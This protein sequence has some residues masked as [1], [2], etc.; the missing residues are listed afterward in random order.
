MPKRDFLQIPDLTADGI[1]SLLELAGRMKAGS[2]RERPLVG[3]T[4]AMVFAKSSTR[5]RVSFEVGA[6]QLGG[7]ALFL[8]SRD[9]QIGR[10]EPIKDTA[11]V[12]SRYVDGIMIRT[13]A[14]ADVVE[15]ARHATV[16]VINGLTDFLHP[17]QILADVMTMQEAFGGWQGRVVAWVGD[18]NN[19]AN[20]WLHA[21]GVLGFE[22]RVAC[23]E[24]YEPDREVFERAKRTAKVSVYEDPE[25]AVRGA[26]VVTTDVW[27]SMGQ[28]AEVDARMLAFKGYNVDAQLM[29]LASPDAIFLHC[30]PAHRGEEVSDAVIEGPQS[31]AFDQAE[32]RLHVQKALMVELMGG[33][34]GR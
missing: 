24:G 16:P 22:L 34:G 15:L 8:S 10:G 29:S 23:P 12:L 9:L 21:A 18:G 31:R 2:Y 11:R 27:A 3:K 25:D 28:E 30:L 6:Y 13:F 26:H 14:H 5:T 4:L 33:E 20:S 17:C 1:G 7:H 32:N 19:V